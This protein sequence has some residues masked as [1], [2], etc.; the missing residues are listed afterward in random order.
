MKPALVLYATREGQTRHI[1]EHLADRLRA[2]GLA[3]DVV[4]VAALPDDFDL[5][6]YGAAVLAASVHLGKHEREMI[7]FV[8]ERRAELEGIPSMFLSVSLTEAEAEDANAPAEKRER[9]AA[10]VRGMI[11]TFL[12]ETG[13]NAGHVHPVAGALLYRHY[14]PLI[15]LIMRYIAKR[16]GA[17]T[18]T[19]SEYEFTDWQMLDRFA[20]EIVAELAPAGRAE[21]QDACAPP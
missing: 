18:D 1:A 9:A 15:R 10:E 3:T 11:D 20:A 8:K 2:R 6:R 5:A 12:I 7:A 13:W 4:G 19:S 16:Q 17:P 21:G 14:G